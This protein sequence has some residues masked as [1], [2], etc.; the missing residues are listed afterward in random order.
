M[1]LYFYNYIYF[2]I[3]GAVQHQV[4]ATIFPASLL[5]SYDNQVGNCLVLN[6]FNLR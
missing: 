4:P 3:F 2:Y 1:Q 5:A 6:T